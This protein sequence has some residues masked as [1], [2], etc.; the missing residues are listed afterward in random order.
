MEVWNSKDNEQKNTIEIRL[1]SPKDEMIFLLFNP[2]KMSSTPDWNPQWEEWHC[3]KNPMVVYRQDYNKLLLPYFER[4]YPT[5]DAFSGE[6]EECFD[7]CF[8]NWIG[9][10][11]WRQFVLEIEGDFDNFLEE[12]K[13]FYKKL[14]NWINVALE[15]TSII[16]VEGNQ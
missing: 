10:K 4:I 14:I 11:D 16:V 3:Y 9:E 6:V 12:E 7:V 1:Y 5:E 2:V 15:Y 13:E 8:S